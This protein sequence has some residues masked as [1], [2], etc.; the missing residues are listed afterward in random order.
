MSAAQTLARHKL[1]TNRSGHPS[2]PLRPYMRNTCARWR[3]HFLQVHHGGL[4]LRG[5]EAVRGAQLGHLD[6]ACLQRCNAR[7]H[8][9]EPTIVDDWSV[10]HLLRTLAGRKHLNSIPVKA[11][12]PV[13][14]RMPSQLC[15]NKLPSSEIGERSFPYLC[16]MSNTCMQIPKACMSN[17][18]RLC[19]MKQTITEECSREFSVAYSINDNPGNDLDHER[20][21]HDGIPP[22][23]Q[24]ADSDAD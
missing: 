14:S 15:P 8:L 16:T 9:T 23:F 21:I 18:G 17:L 7:Q 3:T 6:A 24:T 10:R 11:D 20:S 1:Q 4:D 12:P 22:A 19:S 5:V 13:V 2:L